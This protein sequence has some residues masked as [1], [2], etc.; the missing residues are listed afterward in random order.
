MRDKGSLLSVVERD[1]NFDAIIEISFVLEL[2]LAPR[3]SI[4]SPVAL[5][6]LAIRWYS[7]G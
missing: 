3:L 5:A 2:R 4:Q 7:L 6:L 1:V